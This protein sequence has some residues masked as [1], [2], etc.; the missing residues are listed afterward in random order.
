MNDLP[1]LDGRDPGW[2]GTVIIGQESGT[3]PLH[4][5]TAEAHAIAWREGQKPDRGARKRQLWRAHLTVTHELRY[6]PPGDASLTAVPLD[7]P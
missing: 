3:W 2:E 6:V 4:L 5:F 1:I 7:K